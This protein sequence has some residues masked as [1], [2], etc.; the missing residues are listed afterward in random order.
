MSEPMEEKFRSEMRDYA[1]KYFALH[2]EQRIQTFNFFLVICTLIIGGLIALLKDA[3]DYRVGAAVAFGL[4]FISFIFWKLDVRNTE[5]IHHSEEA[6]KLLE[7]DSRLDT[8]AGVPHRL[9]IFSHEDY[10]TNQRR[11]RMMLFGGSFPGTLATLL[12]SR[13]FSWLWA[14]LASSLELLY[15]SLRN[16]QFSDSLR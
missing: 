6:L 3:K 5:L 7:N 4:T 1:W 8:E 16:V 12:A 10:V 2:S 11:K 15:W 9:K 13:R 14:F